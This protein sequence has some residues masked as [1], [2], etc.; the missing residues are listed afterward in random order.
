MASRRCWPVSAE[1]GTVE[2]ALREPGPGETWCLHVRLGERSAV[3]CSFHDENVLTY[4]FKAK[5]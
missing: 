3:I 5:L 1:P 2:A 4:L